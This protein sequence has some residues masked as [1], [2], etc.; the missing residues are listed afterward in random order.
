MLF[1]FGFSFVQDLQEVYSGTLFE[2]LEYKIAT[3][4]E[5]VYHCEVCSQKGFVC[6]ICRNPKVIYPFDLGDNYRVSNISCYFIVLHTMAFFIN[7]ILS[8]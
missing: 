8:E 7:V 1:D 2:L 6:E 4:R 5:H 3:S